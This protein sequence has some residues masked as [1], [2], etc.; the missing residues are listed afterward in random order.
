M[1]TDLL[2]L[3]GRDHQDIAMGLADLARP[4]TTIGNLRSMLDGV[5]LGLLA[6]AEA[7]DIVFHH[8]LMRSN[9]SP[10]LVG[11]IEDGHGAHR[12][13]QSALGS[14]VSQQPCTPTWRDWAVQ[15]RDLV[16]SH[17]THEEDVIL[18]ALRAAVPAPVWASLAGEFATQRLVQLG[19]LQP[20]APIMSYQQL[21]LL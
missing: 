5:R 6:H 1:T 10:S 13:Q 19:M 20:S 3:L 18:P 11:L 14:L 12:A 7:E 9:Q 4:A 16:V 15:L 8:A 17:A 21:A 2:T